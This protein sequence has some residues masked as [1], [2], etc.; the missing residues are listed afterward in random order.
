M[1]YVVVKIYNQSLGKVVEVESIEKGFNIIHE[2]FK[3]QFDRVMCDDELDDLENLMEIDIEEDDDNHYTFSVG[4]I[5]S[6]S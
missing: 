3:N 4:I 2:W 1:K 5:E 6:E